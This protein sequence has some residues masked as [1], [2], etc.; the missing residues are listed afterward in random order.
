M[1]EKKNLLNQTFSTSIDEN[2]SKINAILE[3]SVDLI[4]RRITFHEHK[5]IRG[6][7]FYTDGLVNTQL[8]EKAIEALQ[9]EGNELLH[10]TGIKEENLEDLI[11]KHILINSSFEN[12]PKVDKAID[13]ILSGGTIFFIE[14]CSKAFH[15]QT[16]GWESR[17]I[18]EPQTEQVVRGPRDGFTENI[19][20]NTALVRRRIRDPLFRIEAMQIGERTKTDVNIGYIKGTVKDGL[21]EE[22]KKRL[23]RIKIDGILESGYIE[24]LIEDTPRS[25]FTTIMSTERPDKVAAAILEGRVV[26]FVDN[27]PFALIVPTYFWQLLQ[28]SDDYYVKYTAGSF[29]RVVRYFAFIISLTLT[30]LYVMLA[31]FHQEMIPTSLALT[32]AAGRETVPFPVLLEAL[33]MEFSFEI[34]REAGLRMPKPVGQAVSIVGSLVIGQ[35]AVQAGVASP[36]MVIIVAI[37]GISSFVIPNY[38]ASYSIRLIRIPLLLASGTLGLLGF[39]T[40]FALI[41]IHALTLRSFGESYLAPASPFQPSDQKDTILRFPWWK[42]NKKPQLADGDPYREGENQ[43]PKPPNKLS[44]D[45]EEKEKA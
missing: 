11:T 33:I 3:N 36:F 22:V 5:N 39:A 7:C 23:E 10:R 18:D 27:T 19:R 45:S 29:F 20:T 40:M 15:V 43:M 8:I 26:I 42:M 21:V 34:M 14:G 30:S 41:A 1:V 38:S 9:Y 12:I 16:K 24:E 32:I 37:T 13:A 28:A 6:L 25:P 4:K 17:S 31:S 44:S 35:A 2:E